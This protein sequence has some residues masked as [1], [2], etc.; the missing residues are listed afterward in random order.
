[1]RG[2]GPWTQIRERCFPA[3]SVY[4]AP[5][6]WEPSSEGQPSVERLQQLW[7]MLAE[8]PSY[9]GL[10]IWPLIPCKRGLLC[11]PGSESQVRLHSLQSASCECGQAFNAD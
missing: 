6:S 11:A 7:R 5:Y 4:C 9:E 1:M 10:H 3:E 2:G 8:L